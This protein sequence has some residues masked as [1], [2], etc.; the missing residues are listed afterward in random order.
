MQTLGVQLENGG[1]NDKSQESSSAEAGV[2]HFAWIMGNDIHS[3][4]RH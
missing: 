4:Y 2:S 1:T 3:T